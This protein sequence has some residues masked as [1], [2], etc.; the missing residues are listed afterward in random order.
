MELSVISVQARVHSKTTA[1]EQKPSEEVEES[2][3]L[4]IDV[5]QGGLKLAGCH[6]GVCCIQ[7]W[8]RQQQSG[9]RRP[10]LHDRRQQLFQRLKR[11]LAPRGKRARRHD[12]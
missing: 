7:E 5:L 12:Q 9:G 3:L 8:P 2:D 10:L 11:Q 4:L 1:T 6:H